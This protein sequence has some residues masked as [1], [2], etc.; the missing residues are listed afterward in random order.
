MDVFQNQYITSDCNFMVASATKA[1]IEKYKLQKNDVLLTKDSETRE[2]IANSAIMLENIPDLI[3]G[4]HLA[5]LR[6]K[7]QFVD[8]LFLAYIINF[9]T[10]HNYFVTRANGVTRFGVTIES[11][12]G[13]MVR[14]PN[15]VEQKKIAFS[16]LNLDNEQK[17]LIQRVNLLKKQKGGLMQKLLNGEVRAKV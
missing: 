17:L 13:L 10:F 12:K 3:C 7:D 2:D 4:Y 14:I 11:I 5:I 8:G 15:L 1:E 16:L 9:G 6:P